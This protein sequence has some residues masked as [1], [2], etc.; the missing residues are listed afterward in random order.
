MSHIV[1][2]R[3]VID[4]NVL[5]RTLWHLLMLG[6]ARLLHHRDAAATLRGDVLRAEVHVRKRGS[7]K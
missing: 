4:G 3:H 6:V 2:R 5:K 7:Q 1:Q